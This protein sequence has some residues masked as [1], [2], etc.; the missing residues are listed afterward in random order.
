V[1]GG[2]ALGIAARGTDSLMGT[3]AAG[4]AGGPALA[5]GGYSGAGARARVVARV[6]MRVCVA[7]CAFM[8]A[9]VVRVCCTSCARSAFLRAAR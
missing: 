9:H 8:R 6:C 7:A 3:T 4:A 2:T 1:T 5:G